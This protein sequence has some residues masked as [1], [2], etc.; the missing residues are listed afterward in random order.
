MSIG[1]GTSYPFEVFG[2]PVLKGFKFS[3]IPESIPGKSMYPPCEGELCLGLDLRDFYQTHSAMFGRIN[4]AWL[5]MAYR[6]LGSSPDFFTS[7][8]DILAGTR[9]LRKQISAGLPESQ[10]R[11]SWQAGIEKFK[12]VREK[13][14]L[15]E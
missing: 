14:L 4:L 12:Q 2:H 15:Y 10:I 3:F 9:E 8:F 13:Y 11:Q 7:Y 5:M 1:R 6:N